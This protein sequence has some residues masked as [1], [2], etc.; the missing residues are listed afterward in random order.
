[1]LPDM[2][3]EHLRCA[4]AEAAF[5][6]YQIYIKAVVVISTDAPSIMCTGIGTYYITL[7]TDFFGHG[8]FRLDPGSGGQR[9]YVVAQFRI[10]G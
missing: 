3:F 10:I 5:V 2:G 9:G 7:F 8:V 1:M 4:G 6:G